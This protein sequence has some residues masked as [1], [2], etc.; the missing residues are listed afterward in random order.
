ME[1]FSG[2]FNGVEWKI[3]WHG[4]DHVWKLKESLWDL[5]QCCTIIQIIDRVSFIRKITFYEIYENCR[6]E[7]HDQYYSRSE[8]VSK[9]SDQ[10]IGKF[11]VTY[12]WLSLEKCDL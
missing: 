12:L 8:F 10:K 3:S 4:H 6:Q 9:I 5:L 7:M 2:K 1:N 11:F